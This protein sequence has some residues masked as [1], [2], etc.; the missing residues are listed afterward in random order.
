[1]SK[2][3]RD[4]GV[5]GDHAWK[6]M[7]PAELPGRVENALE[8][9][10]Y[11]TVGAL[12]DLLDQ[13]RLT[14]LDGVGDGSRREVREAF[15]QLV[16]TGPE[17]FRFGPQGRPENLPDLC[18]RI[19]ESLSGRR[20]RIVRGYVVEGESLAA[21]GKDLGL[22][23]E[24]V[25]QLKDSAIRELKRR[26][27]DVAGELLR[28][29]LARTERSG[30]LLPLSQIPVEFG[31]ED[32]SPARALELILRCVDGVDLRVW[33][34][35]FLTTL[36][37]PKLEDT[38]DAL[39][40]SVS[41][42]AALEISLDHIRTWAEQ[43]GLDLNTSEACALALETFGADLR[44]GPVVA[45]WLNTADLV[46]EALR[47]VRRAA[48]PE[49]ILREYDAIRRNLES[50]ELSELDT[51]QI[52]NRVRRHDDAINYGHGVY[53]HIDNLPMPLDDLREAVDWAVGRVRGE[54]DAISTK[55]LLDEMDRER[56]LP[57]GL[58]P[59][60]LKSELGDRPGIVGLKNT[61]LVADVDSY[62]QSNA[63]M[64]AR[65]E[66]VLREASGPLSSSDVADQLEKYS[67]SEKSIQL[68]LGRAD[69]AVRWGRSKYFH[70]EQLGLDADERETLLDA[71]EEVLPE[72]GTAIGADTV[73][74]Y[75]SDEASAILQRRANPPQLLWALADASECFE[76]AS[77]RLIARSKQVEQGL[78]RRTILDFLESGPGT[79]G[80]IRRWL[81]RYHGYAGA[82]QNI[83][84]MLN[85]LRDEG[86]VERDGEGRYAL[87]D[88]ERSA[89]G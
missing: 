27:G 43:R 84:G 28:P 80:E 48:G 25:R 70:R 17:T 87:G 39:A 63:D 37:D 78:L 31:E 75:V 3:L 88:P 16:Q 42:T 13:N 53:I 89:P 51:S 67:Y 62:E 50:E 77:G 36:A 72:D 45:P 18:S 30:G 66:A 44:D 24:R 6:K 69:V 76:T 58:T 32:A 65:V 86:R 55:A 9:E 68:A 61:R 81:K 15:E 33:N 85:T 82:N 20:Q 4:A 23:R 1:V 52:Q 64:V 8:Q 47:R 41:G 71:I 2:R 26:F 7:F 56:I 40:T 79:S 57:P 21:V 34:E 19:V 35:H 49:E 10:G 60:L 73:A 14:A 46:V 59:H 11:R 29:L 74:E 38:F 22:S 54:P 12:A 5:D 83:T